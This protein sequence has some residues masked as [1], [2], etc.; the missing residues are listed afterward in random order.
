MRE[1]TQPPKCA[2]GGKPITKEQRPSVLLANGKEVHVE[3][4]KPFE[5]SQRKFN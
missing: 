1:E 2:Y 5:Q 3:C 4:W